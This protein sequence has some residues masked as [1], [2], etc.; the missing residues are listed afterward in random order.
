[1][2]D[3]TENSPPTTRGV[4]RR[5]LIKAGAWAAPVLVLRP[6]RLAPRRRQADPA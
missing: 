3:I 4:N 6:P 1:M 2:T 5:Q